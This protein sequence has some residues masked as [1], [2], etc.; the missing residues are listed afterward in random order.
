MKAR[1]CLLLI[2]LSSWFALNTQ[3]QELKCMVKVNTPKLQT[4]DP[5]VF[6]TL[7]KSVFEFM[8]NRKWTD[9]AYEVTEKIECSM[10]ITVT[11][12]L[13]SD[14]FKLQVTIQSSRPVHNS[15]YTTTLFN[16]SDKDWKVNYVEYQPLEYEDNKYISNLTSML[17]FYAYMVIGLDYDSFSAKGGQAYFD[18]AKNIVNIMQNVDED[19]WKPFEK[20]LKNRYWINENIINQ[21]FESFRMLMYNYHRLGLDMMYTNE[22]MG[23]ATILNC[24]KQLEKMYEDSPNAVWIGIFFASKSD[25]LAN[26]FAGGTPQEKQQSYQILTRCDPMNSNRYKRITGAR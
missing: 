22:A 23:R 15:S 7:Q 3:A 10:L 18:K 17:A 26:I 4:T 11:E 25:E 2:I 5:R 6:Q 20:N 24:L 21:R 8:N 13:G 16:F 12:E 1:I 14:N 9:D 19:G